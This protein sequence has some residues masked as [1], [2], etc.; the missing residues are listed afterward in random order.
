MVS[1]LQNHARQLNV[2]VA[3]FLETVCSDQDAAQ[4]EKFQA[5]PWA[6]EEREPRRGLYETAVQPADALGL[7]NTN[8]DNMKFPQ[9][10]MGWQCS[11]IGL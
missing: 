11:E 9:V 8:L 7:H 4:P 2:V 3:T 10:I 5:D 6:H 1:S